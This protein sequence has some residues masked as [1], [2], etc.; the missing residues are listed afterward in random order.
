MDSFFFVLCSLCEPVC[1]DL[2][3]DP[4]CHVKFLVRAGRICSCSGDCVGGWKPVSCV[5]RSVCSRVF[6]RTFMI[7]KCAFFAE[8]LLKNVANLHILTIS[9]TKKRFGFIMPSMYYELQ[10]C[11]RIQNRGSNEVLDSNEEDEKWQQRKMPRP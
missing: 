9:L 1:N 3:G 10:P 7:Q 2:S 5:H 8:N 6:D 11:M 4:F